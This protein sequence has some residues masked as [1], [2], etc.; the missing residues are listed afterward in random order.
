MT[1]VTSPTDLL[2]HLGKRQLIPWLSIIKKVDKSSPNQNFF[3]TVN[4]L[5]EKIPGVGKKADK[6]GQLILLSISAISVS[7]AHLC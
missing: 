5:L 1:S 7:D 4:N 6:S 2:N 3:R